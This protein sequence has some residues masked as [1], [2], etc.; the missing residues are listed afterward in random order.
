MWE[1]FQHAGWEGLDNLTAII[2]VNRLG[3]T[4]E[5]MLGWDLHGYV[6]RIEAFGWKAIAIDGHD[7]GAIEAAYRR[8]RGDERPADGDRRPHQEGQGRQ[9]GRGPPGQARQAARRSRAGDRGARRRAPT[10]RVD[11]AGPAGRQSRTSSRRPAAGCRRRQLGDEDATRKAYGESIAALGGDPRRRRRARRRGLELAR[12]PRI[13]AR[14][15]PTATSRCSSPSSSW[16]SAAIGMQARGWTP[17]VST[18]SA[19]LVARVRLHPHGRD[20]ARQAAL[21]RLARRR[22]D[23][24]GRPVAD[25]AGGHRLDPRDPRLDRAAPERRQPDREAGRRRWPTATASRSSA[26]CAAKTPVRTAPREAVHIGGSRDR[27]RGRR[28]G[29]RRVR[30]H[31]RRGGQGRRAARRRRASTRAC[32]TPTRSSRSTPTPS[33]RRRASAARS[34][35]SRTTRPRAA[36]GTRCSRRSPTGDEHAH[37]VKLAVREMPASGTPEELLHGGGDRRRRDR[38]RRAEARRRPA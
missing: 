36:S 14:R 16:S 3:Q 9:G 29:D 24:R 33:A 2:D 20:L 35:P 7:V 23:R 21:S 28:R 32:S 12:T 37:V 10:C 25:G 30:D 6:R 31:G 11:V 13:S 22:L 4:R 15:T 8:G 38:R 5:T 1:A 26:R 18:F 19:F 27:A 34:S 17:F